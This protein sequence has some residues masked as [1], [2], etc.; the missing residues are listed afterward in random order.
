MTDSKDIA[1]GFDIGTTTSCAAIWI[2]DRVE[3]IPDT[4]T[5]SRIIPSYVSFSDEEKLV[6]DAAKNQTA[7]NPT[8]TVFDAKRLIGRK[9]SDK[10]VQADIKLWPFKVESGAGEKPMIVVKFKG[11][12]KKF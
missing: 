11:E 7:R 10:T 1:A 3:I 9:F 2:N 5:G 8:N 12:T 6:G 4:Q